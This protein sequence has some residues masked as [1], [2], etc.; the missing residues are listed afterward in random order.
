MVFYLTVASVPSI[1]SILNEFKMW[2]VHVV[3]SA[4]AVATQEEGK[5]NKPNIVWV[6]ADGS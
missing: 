4:A 3:M 5:A 2:F 6:M 1:V